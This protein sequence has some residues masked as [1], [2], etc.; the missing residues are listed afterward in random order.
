MSQ[1]AVDDGPTVT[2]H[3]A[4][5]TPWIRPARKPF[6][7]ATRRHKNREDRRDENP[8]CRVAARK[9]WVVHFQGFRCA[10]PLAGMC[11]RVAASKN[12]RL[13]TRFLQISRDR[14][15]TKRP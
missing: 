2:R 10:P 9:L 15:N 5:R 3:G 6:F 4:G 7:A 8:V 14:L 11:R 13:A 12:V 1:D